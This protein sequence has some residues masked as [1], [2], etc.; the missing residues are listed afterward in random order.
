MADV[1]CVVPGCP[2]SPKRESGACSMHAERKRK[3]GGYGSAA[4]TRYRRDDPARPVCSI[5]SCGSPAQSRGWCSKHYGRWRKHGDPLVNQRPGVRVGHIGYRLVWEPT[6]PLAMV[7]GYVMEHRKVV[8]DAGIHIPPGHHV[9]HIN[10]DK[11][12]NRLE[13]LE[14]KS[15]SDHSREH[16]EEA[17]FVTNQYGTFPV[18]PR[19]QRGSALYPSQQ[20]HR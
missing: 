3:T 19:G 7:D 14:V 4:P 11:L 18:K 17:G 8:H 16:A 1:T 13:N 9:H 15:A 20:A 5:E 2:K 10:G 12:D 6:H